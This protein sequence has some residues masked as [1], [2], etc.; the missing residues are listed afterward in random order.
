MEDA[1]DKFARQLIEADGIYPEYAAWL[2]GRSADQ[3]KTTDVAEEIQDFGTIQWNGRPLDGIIVKTIVTQQ[4][5]I[6]GKNERCVLR[7]RLS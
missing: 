4:N 6:L 3:W 5:R 2:N 1:T 7:L